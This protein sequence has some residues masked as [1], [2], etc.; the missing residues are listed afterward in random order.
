M[1]A[2]CNM[3]SLVISFQMKQCKNSSV[4]KFIVAAILHLATV[5]FIQAQAK[6]HDT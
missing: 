1:H 6:C 2:A 3:P 5:L 4:L